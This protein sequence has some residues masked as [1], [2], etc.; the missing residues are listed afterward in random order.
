MHDTYSKT[1]KLSKTITIAAMFGKKHT[2][3]GFVGTAWLGL[4]LLDINVQ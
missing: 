3:T 4:D 2:Y 1:A